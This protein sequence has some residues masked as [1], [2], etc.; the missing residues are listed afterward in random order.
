MKKQFGILFALFIMLGGFVGMNISEVKAN[1]VN[2]NTNTN[3]LATT[4]MCEIYD[5]YIGPAYGGI[6]SIPC[7]YYGYDNTSDEC[8]DARYLMASRLVYP[9]PEINVNVVDATGK[10]I[11]PNL[12]KHYSRAVKAGSEPFG[13]AIGIRF[14]VW[15]HERRLPDQP[16]KTYACQFITD[17]Y[18]AIKAAAFWNY[19]DNTKVF[20]PTITDIEGY[21]YKGYY[22]HNQKNTIKYGSLKN[23]LT[24]QEILFNKEQ[25]AN[26]EF[27]I[28]ITDLNEGWILKARPAILN[29]TYN[30]I[31][32]DPV[33]N[34]N[35]LLTVEYNL[36]YAKF[37]NISFDSNTGTGKVVDNNKYEQGQEFSLVDGSTLKKD[38]YVFAGWNTKADGTGTTYKANAKFVMYENT[39]LYAQWTVPTAE[40]TVLPKTGNEI[41]NIALVLITLSSSII[42]VKKV[43]K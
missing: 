35:Q 4:E 1:D 20:A 30:E 26:P 13:Y 5:P 40:A 24:K 12:K 17:N 14:L 31:D 19:E 42:L 32:N 41:L 34:I 8:K 16:Q 22:Y 11:D 39:T 2:A 18:S 25:E 43:V 23:P 33:N 29:K 9:N 28:N 38:G 37:I 27:P 3:V 6:T 36:V 21:T 10:V 7:E 15:D